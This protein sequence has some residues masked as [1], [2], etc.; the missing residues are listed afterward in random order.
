MEFDRVHGDGERSGDCL[1]GGALRQQR[2]HI[3]LSGREGHFRIER[4]FASGHERRIRRFPRRGETKSRHVS[5]NR[6][7]PIGERRLADLD[8]DD[9]RGG[10]LFRHCA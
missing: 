1:V 7:Q 3:E 5:Q 9:D 2:E 6:R 10:G 8:R 4:S